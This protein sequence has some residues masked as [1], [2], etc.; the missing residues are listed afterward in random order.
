ME[1]VSRRDA[2]AAVAAG[3]A[4]AAAAPVAA[5]AVK[6]EPKPK[7]DLKHLEER[8]ELLAKGMAK[9]GDGK[10]LRELIPIIRKPGWTTPAEFLLVT[11]VVDS[12]IAHA[13]GLAGL[14]DAL[15][16]GSRAVGAP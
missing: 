14:K 10:D 2:L 8:L 16:K 15:V 7:H 5:G 4:L 12:M 13:E 9:L 6:D 3:V 11:G 1:N